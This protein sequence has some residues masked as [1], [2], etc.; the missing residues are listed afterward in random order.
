MSESSVATVD[1][2]WL[3]PRVSGPLITFRG[4]NP[5]VSEIEREAQAALEAGFRRGHS[6]GLAAAAAEVNAR[7][8][9]LDE[10]IASLGSII[11]RL[12]RPLDRLDEVAASELAQ[13]A[14]TVGGQLARRTLEQDPSAIIDIVRDCLSQLPA[15]SREIRVHLN[16]LDIAAIRE[17]LATL[18]EASGW[19]L[20][21][22]RAVGRGGVRV[23]VDASTIDGGL[24]SRVAAAL[25]A[26]LGDA[27]RSV[28]HDLTA[29]LD[30]EG[31]PR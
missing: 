31:P 21:E 5:D 27:R 26:V 8:R 7:L 9:L 20:L 28:S 14:V 4:K 15:A 10:R 23:T 25:T 18:P 16:P 19:S 17:Q 1:R 2:V 6:E 29:E 30:A 3:P 22:D 11:Q 13:L 24:D 12:A